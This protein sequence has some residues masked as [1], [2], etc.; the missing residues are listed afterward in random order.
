MACRLNRLIKLIRIVHRNGY[1]GVQYLCQLFQIKERTL[2]NDLKELKEELGVEIQYDKLKRGYFLASD[3]SEINLMALNQESSILL[4]AAFGLLK[5]YAGEAFATP[6]NGIFNE[7]INLCLKNG[8]AQDPAELI[9][10]EALSSIVEKD[11]FVELCKACLNMEAV[12]VTFTEANS[13]NDGQEISKENG[14]P[15]EIRPKFLEFSDH[16]WQLVYLN[17]NASL[18]LQRLSL[19]SIKG[20]SKQSQ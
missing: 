17:I 6:L 20:V 5:C 7:E 12:T 2:F 14:H 3:A 1:P 8:H 15:I 4:L 19:E 11:I 10:T 16:Q 18:E 9:K 13:K